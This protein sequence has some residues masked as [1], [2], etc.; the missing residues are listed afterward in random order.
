MSDFRDAL[1]RILT[2]CN[3]SSKYSRRTQQIHETSMYALGLT[4]S[5]RTARHIAVFDR[6][7]DNPAKASFQQRQARREARAAAG[8]P[9]APNDD[10]SAYQMWIATLPSSDLPIDPY[11]AFI[12]GAG[13]ARDRAAVNRAEFQPRLVYSQA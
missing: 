2:L 11:F 7:G 9:I 4:E 6:I 10:W 13:S 5:Q 1:E 8:N 12:S 3:T